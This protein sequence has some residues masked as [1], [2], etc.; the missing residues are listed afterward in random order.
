MGTGTILN[1]QTLRGQR[2]LST[3]EMR[4]RT[5]I[6]NNRGVLS[7]IARELNLSLAFVQR[8]AY[9]REAASKG[10]RVEHRLKELGCPLIQKIN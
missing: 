3:G 6:L 10:L 8:V 1:A 9:N 7:R 5:W 4:V 2:E